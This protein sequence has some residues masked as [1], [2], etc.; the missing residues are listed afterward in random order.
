MNFSKD[1]ISSTQFSSKMKGYNKDEVSA[2]IDK[3][4]YDYA[5]F[6]AQIASLNAKVA[7]LTQQLD[8]YRELESTMQQT[9]SMAQSTAEQVRKNAEAKASNIIV[10][11]ENKARAI[12]DSAN[13]MSLQ[14]K[15][16]MDSYK[17]QAYLY[18]NK[19]LSMLKTQIDL[20]QEVD[21]DGTITD[22]SEGEV[23]A[24]EE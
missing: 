11:A 18:K 3:V 8:R 17:R 12:V 22:G 23:K 21:S 9:L 7:E 19:M 10:E 15:Y 1:N 13:N 20:L 4:A 24:L 14:I 5:E 2:F 6:D 16:D